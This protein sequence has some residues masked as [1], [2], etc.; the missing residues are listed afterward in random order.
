MLLKNGKLI[1]SKRNSQ[2]QV[3]L[4][5]YDGSVYQ[6]AYMPNQAFWGVIPGS[7]TTPVTT[8]DYSI[9]DVQGLT[10]ITNSA[11]Y[12]NTYDDD[13]IA[14]FST[15]YKNS[16]NADITV[17]EFGALYYDTYRDGFQHYYITRD[18]LEEPKV[19]HPGESYTFTAVIG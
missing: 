4:K 12:G 2:E 18:V 8:D 3:N 11:S 19:I 1:L 7:G 17:N 10:R 14:A 16:T 9:T 15:T 6:A 5:S 13:F